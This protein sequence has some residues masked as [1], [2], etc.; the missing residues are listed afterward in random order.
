MVRQTWSLQEKIKQTT[1]QFVRIQTSLETRNDAIL[2][3]RD[4]VRDVYLSCS[5]YCTQGIGGD[6]LQETEER[7]SDDLLVAVRDTVGGLGS[8]AG[9]MVCCRRAFGIQRL[10]LLMKKRHCVTLSK[11]NNSR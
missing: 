1:N 4:P 5:S 2:L 3:L 6:A 11:K 7:Q 8:I 9:K 10:P